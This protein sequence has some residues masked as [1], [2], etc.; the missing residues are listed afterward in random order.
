MDSTAPDIIVNLKKLLETPLD[1]SIYVVWDTSEPVLKTDL[2]SAITHF[3]DITSIS[4]RTWLVNFKQGYV[5]E[6]HWCGLKIIGLADKEKILQCD[7]L[8]RCLDALTKVRFISRSNYRQIHR[9]LNRFSQPKY[10][11]ITSSSS[12]KSAFDI[13]PCIE[14]TLKKSINKDIYLLWDDMCLQTLQTDLE[15]IIT[16]WDTISEV[17]QPF[18]IIDTNATYLINFGLEHGTRINFNLGLKST[19]LQINLL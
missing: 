3:D 16:I 19:N 4:T 15:S 13:I 18:Q 1:E 2:Y 8:K 9:L 7:S 6:W 14:T 12:V 10:W 11:D 5:I 17:K